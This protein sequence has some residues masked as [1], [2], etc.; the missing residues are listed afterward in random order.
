MTY[1]DDDLSE[2]LKNTK[3]AIAILFQVTSEGTFEWEKGRYF[4]IFARP[5][6]RIRA[7]LE[8]EREVLIVGNLY[9]DQQARTIAFAQQAIAETKGRLE[10]KLFFVVHSDPKGN[11]KLKKWG[12]ESGLTVIPLYASSGKLPS[13]TELERVLSYEFF[14]HNPFDVTGPVESDSQFFGRRTEAQELARKLQNGQIRA[15]FGIRK[16]GKTSIM[17]RVLSEI[18]SNFDC[19]TV[20]IDCQQ[21]GVFNLSA[22][23]LLVSVAATIEDALSTKKRVAELRTI[24]KSFNLFDAS[25]IFI[26][27]I[28]KLDEP[29]VLAFDEIDYITPGS[30]TAS[31]WKTDFIEFW[32]N[33]RAG[34]QAAARSHRNVSVL[35]CGVSSKWFSVEA[36]NGVE[37]AALSF[38]P[39]EYLTPLPRGAAVAMIRSVGSMAGLQFGE[40]EASR[41]A[42][43]CSDMPFWIR[44]ACSFIHLRTDTARRPF[45]VSADYIETELKAFVRDEGSALA[46]VALQHLF[47]VYP[48]LR[49]PALLFSAQKA[50]EVSSTN[51][52]LLTRYGLLSADG[53]ISGEMVRAGLE[54]VKSEP[55]TA[56]VFDQGNNGGQVTEALTLSFDDWAE[57]LQVIG[58]RRN[59]LERRMREIVFNF[60][61]FAAL[62]STDKKS[63]KD[64]IM[65]CIPE[66]RRR[67]LSNH[68]I[69]E[70]SQKIFWLELCAIVRREWQLFEKLFGDQQRFQENADI[71]NDR[72]DA[73]AKAVD[74]ADIALYR[75]SL[76][77]FEDKLARL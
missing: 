16:I 23:N 34:Y 40:Q 32:R 11:A 47:R 62:S 52:R 70:I 2:L 54:L 56:V 76:S 30:P 48:E 10:P 12:R 59:I 22:P 26:E 13:G 6:K 46:Q 49:E 65:A 14:S 29:L 69:D 63:A 33:I 42:A 25:R 1:V 41:I 74:R 67:E 7:I 38:V 5:A 71:I 75:R 53:A 28:E 43:C 21:D 31:H 45:R 57:E 17:H 24:S 64:R 19:I 4:K 50:E 3:N 73:H 39:E 55:D 20:F 8:V 66:Q 51:V 18:E 61:K 58:K 44:K 27:T 15:C 68:N 35:V 77:W 9:R 37:N 72:P 36:I 60:V